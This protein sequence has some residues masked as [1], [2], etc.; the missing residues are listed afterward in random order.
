MATF[1]EIQKMFTAA[2]QK[3]K[4]LILSIIRTIIKIIKNSNNQKFPLFHFKINNQIILS[5][6]IKININ[7]LKIK[8]KIK[9]I[10]VILL[11]LEVLMKI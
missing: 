10:K 8:S 11:I 5:L 7:S 2:A 1:Q 3:N 4:H 6:Q 9:A